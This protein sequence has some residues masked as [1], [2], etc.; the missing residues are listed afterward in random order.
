[1]RLTKLWLYVNQT[2]VF[3]KEMLKQALGVVAYGQAAPK[4]C[5]LVSFLREPGR[6]RYELQSMV[7]LKF[8]I[9]LAYQVLDSSA[10]F[11]LNI[12]PAF[13]DRQKIVEEQLLISQS[14][15]YSELTNNHDGSRFIKLKAHAGP[16]RVNYQGVVEINHFREN[17]AVLREMPISE[18]S[19]DILPFVYPS[20]YCQSDRL[21]A[22]ANYEFGA[23]TPGFGR[24]RA[25]RQWVNNRTK[26]IT[27]S[28]GSTT[29]S[30]DTLIDHAGVCRD[31]AHLMIA[32]CRALNMPAR[33][34]SG[35]D[36]GADPS[37][38]PT[39]F[40]A[41]VEVM[42][43]GRWYIFDPSGVSPPMGLIRLGTGRD[44]AEASFATVFGAVVSQTP[45]IVI[46][47]L[48]DNNNAYSLPYHYD[49]AFSSADQT[50]GRFRQTNH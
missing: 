17:P 45:V 36:Y 10:D 21:A 33:F 6:N 46:E 7:K 49:D 40:H 16:L 44:A 4:I 2:P 20:R 8:S 14:I 50:P 43:S 1:M 22:L 18:L 11:V 48:L 27:G 9:E 34:V 42:L 28:S 37:L 5:T 26:F 41:Y 47:A 35:I 15:P 30:M 29:S 24:V 23:M 32:L 12:Q 3:D 25:I 13:T 39:D 19:M 38:G 31:F